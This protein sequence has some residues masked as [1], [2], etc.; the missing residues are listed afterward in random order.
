MTTQ[1]QIKRGTTTPSG[2]TVGEPAFD[3]ATSRLF[4]GNTAAVR[5]VGGE[6]TGGFDMGAGSAASQNRV[7]TQNAVYEYARRNFVASFNGA[8]GAISGV[9][10]IVAGT[11]ITISPTG[12]TG[13]VTI[14][15]AQ[16][17]VNNGTLTMGT[18]GNGISGTQTFTA[19]QSGNATFTVTSNAT[20]A[21]TGST[22]V[23]RD[24]SGNF[25]AGTITAA[26]TGTASNASS[27]GN[28]AASGWAQLAAANTFSAANS[29]NGLMTFTAG[30]SGNGITLSG[31]LSAATKSFVIPHPTKRGMRLQYASLEGP[32]N[33]VYVR[34][35]TEEAVIVLP[36]YWTGLVHSDS[37]TVNLTPIGSG[38]LH[39]V[40]SIKG[41]KVKIASASGTINCFYTVYA[42]RKDVP[43]LQVEG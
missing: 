10:S 40:K 30:L 17:T 15:A 14:N 43:R 41:N 3:T 4:I 22:I 37:I 23:F 8:T 16:P 27:L 21:N 24:A 35:R 1:I 20:N 39:W 36:D 28:T 7:P 2:L 13:A 19:N 34:G 26:L 5:W 18:S 12:G 42:E 6:I 29:F 32:E 38:D 25:S 33:G 11:N 31:N 9:G